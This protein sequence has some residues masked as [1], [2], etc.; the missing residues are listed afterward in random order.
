MCYVLPV[1]EHSEEQLPPPASG[2]LT[3]RMHSQYDS[4]RKLLL[5]A[6]GAELIIPED[7]LSSAISELNYGVPEKSDKPVTLPADYSDDLREYYCPA[8]LDNHRN[9]W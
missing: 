4:D 3:L 1:K 6:P 8:D 2:A 7:V 5:C 9:F